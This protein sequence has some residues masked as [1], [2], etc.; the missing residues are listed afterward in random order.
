MKRLAIG[1]FLGILWASPEQRR[2]FA[3]ILED[4]AKMLRGET[5]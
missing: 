5:P 1:F 2:E 3:G 4:T